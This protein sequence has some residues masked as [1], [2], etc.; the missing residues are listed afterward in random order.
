M[1]IP[2]FRRE[3]PPTARVNVDWRRGRTFVVEMSERP[4][5]VWEVASVGELP[6]GADQ[7]DLGAAVRDVLTRRGAE[8]EG[9]YDERFEELLRIAGVRSWSEYVAG[10]RS[11]E[12]SREGETFIVVAREN[13]GAREGLAA[14]GESAQRLEAPSPA[15]LGEA[16]A[17]ALG[18]RPA[19]QLDAVAH[20]R[21]TGSPPIASHPFGR[22]AAWLAL[23]GENPLAVGERL[24]LSE[25]RRE[26]WTR[27]MSDLE[28]SPAAVFVTPSMGGWVLVL[29][30]ESS[31][32]A[33]F[34]LQVLSSEFGE[35]QR[36]ASHRVVDY[37][38]WERWKDGAL[39]RRYAWIGDEGRVLHDE[40]EPA[41]AEAAAVAGLGSAVSEIASDAFE[42]IVLD[43]AREW[44]VDPMDPRAEHQEGSAGVVGYLRGS[45]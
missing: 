15:A 23:R 27:G 19:E 32:D 11:V 14:R 3:V 25:M 34:D 4:T 36:F 21:D 40:G 20:Q 31:A 22:K 17:R 13:R 29:L 8:L 37:Y 45:D 35:A 38:R 26:A 30:G 24:G 12:I 2:F 18:R 41:Q 39:V 6:L 1:R 33:D 5:G 28:S 9:P 44:S 16:V 7:E 10:L 43:V 42:A